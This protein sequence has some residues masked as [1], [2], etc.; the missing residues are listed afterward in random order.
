[1]KKLRMVI[2]TALILMFVVFLAAAFQT[3]VGAYRISPGGFF[4]VS[5][6][7]LFETSPGS[8]ANVG[9]LGN[10][11]NSL[12]ITQFDGA[13]KLGSI[14]QVQACGTATACSLTQPS[15]LK[16]VFGSCTA[17]AATTCTITALPFTSTGSYFCFAQDTTTAANNAL[18]IANASASSTVIT[19]TSS[20][21]VFNYQCIGT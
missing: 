20:S 6:A 10:A 9:I 14:S 16:Q 7:Q 13:T 1:M 3:N 18:K 8:G 21:D 11:S 17:A 2:G 5:G 4:E 15:A 12:F 19:T